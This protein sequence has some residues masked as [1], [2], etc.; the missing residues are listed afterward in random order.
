MKSKEFNAL[1][2][3]ASTDNLYVMLLSQGEVLGGKSCDSIKKHSE[4]VMT[5]ID[6]VLKLGGLKLSD[7]DVFVC[8]VGCGS[9]TGLR[10]AIS[11]VKGLNAPL[12]KKLV[13]VN[14]LETLAYNRAGTTDAV[15]D[16]G[17]GRFYHARYVDGKANR[18]A[19]S[20]FRRAGGGAWSGRKLR[21]FRQRA[22]FERQACG[23][24][25][26]QNS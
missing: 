26:R 22:G 10:V 24:W 9:F 18:C 13:A 14:T 23:A 16:A 4:T 17:G 5:E 21:V 19:A 15:M 7:V 25:P 2:I 8:G 1:I 6:R 11:T 20:Y 3:D 12:G